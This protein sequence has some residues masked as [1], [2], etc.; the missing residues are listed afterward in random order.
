MKIVLAMIVLLLTG[1][2]TIG[3]AAESTGSTSSMDAQE[4]LVSNFN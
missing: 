4:S 1:L 3:H 2:M